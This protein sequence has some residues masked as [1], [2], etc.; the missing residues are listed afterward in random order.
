MI[1]PLNNIYYKIKL[2][3]NENLSF[4]YEN[5][6]FLFEIAPLA[7]CNKKQE[8]MMQSNINI[9]IMWQI[10]LMIISLS[11]VYCNGSDDIPSFFRRIYNSKWRHVYNRYIFSCVTIYNEINGRTDKEVFINNGAHIILGRSDLAVFYFIFFSAL[12]I[13]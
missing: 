9:F 1:A 8:A 4:N 3:Q 10:V 13:D 7:F 12:H 11:N 6:P 5:L 2:K